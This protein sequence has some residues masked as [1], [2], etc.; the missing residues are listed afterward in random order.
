MKTRIENMKRHFFLL[1]VSVLFMVSNTDAYSS[2]KITDPIV[3]EQIY[4][5]TSTAWVIP[6]YHDESYDSMGYPISTKEELI[7]WELNHA[8]IAFGAN[9]DKPVAN[10]IVNL[11]YMYTQK[12]DFSPSSV[13]FGLQAHAKSVNDNYEDYFLHFSE[14][15][16]IQILDSQDSALTPL[17]RRPWLAGW[18]S[19]EDHTGFVIWQNPPYQIRPFKDSDNGGC[20]F[21]YMPEKFDQVEFVLAE[22][23]TTGRIEVRYPASIDITTGV[24]N[25]WG[26]IESNIVDGTNGLRVSGSV[27]WQPP[28]D[29]IKAATYDP[30]SGTGQYFGNTPIELGHKFYVIKICRVEEDIND[31]PVVQDLMTKDFMPTIGELKRLIRGWDPAND[32]NGDGYV[33]NTEFNNL[34]NSTATARFRYESRVTPLGDMWSQRSN[35]QRPNFLNSA[36]RDAIVQV[37][38]QQWLDNGLAGAYNDDVFKLGNINT[39][40]IGG[41]VAEYGINFNDPIF[42]EQ[43]QDAY[44]DTISAIKVETQSPWV[45]ANTSAENL[46][47]PQNNRAR[48][49]DVFDVFLREDYIR[50][51]MGLDGY[52]GI[53]KM[54]ENFALAYSGKKSLIMAHAG[55]TGSIPYVNSKEEWEA[56]IATGLAMYY[57]LNIPGRT[58]YSSWN[59]S[60]NYGSGNTVEGNYYKAGIPKNIAYQ[61]S[62]MLA[63]DIGQPTQSIQEWSAETVQPLRYTAKTALDD[64]A[65]IGDS[66]Q[67]ELTHDEI[68]TFGQVGVIPVIPSNI[69][70]AWQSV[71]TI[72]IGGVEHPKQMIIARDYSNGLVLY[73]TDFFG[74]NADF[75][76]VSHELTLPA[77]Y[78]R[79]NY[80]GTLQAQAATVSLTGYEGVVLVKSLP[81]SILRHPLSQTIDKGSAVT[82][83]VLA[84]GSPVVSYQWLRDDVPIP[85]ATSSNYSITA[86][87]VIDDGII[88]RCKVTNNLG[89]ETSDG[90]VLTVNFVSDLIF[91]DGF[92]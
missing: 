87:S 2:N 6:G 57:L 79:L 54:W 45:G 48:Y 66:T 92:Q 62:F 78:H 88:F 89:T 58:S 30:N 5:S 1:A 80:D 51:G 35:F 81:A 36:Y 47:Y 14:D 91:T 22:V 77:G 33:D 16:P 24:V 26:T 42:E 38:K 64:Y 41:E 18:T 46:F 50:P 39:I 3:P 84:T 56:R 29:W 69:Y 34:V 85:G 13:G 60:F 40:G 52:F 23:A 63:V 49:A 31:Q 65:I 70:L 43:Y 90:A 71:D 10:E 8:D 86:V 73:H 4:P 21:V 83:S 72:T 82:F 55:W 44:L 9:Y 37:T 7:D 17:N 19:R 12:I 68:A 15:T 32:L 74:G 76:S 25:Q 67:S 53:A 28:N 59:S 27:S 11:G 75:M 20:L 61:P